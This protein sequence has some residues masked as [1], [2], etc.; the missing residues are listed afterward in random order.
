MHHHSAPLSSLKDPNQWGPPPKRREGGGVASNTTTAP[1]ARSPRSA[2]QQPTAAAAALEEPGEARP[3]KPF[4]ANTTGLDTSHLPKPPVFRGAGRSPSPS[5]QAAAALPKPRPDLPPRLPPRQPSNTTTSMP[6]SPPP[7]Y[8]ATPTPREDGLNQASLNGLG[9]AG[10]DI[11]EL[12]I[13]S[14]NTPSPSTHAGAATPNK[15]TLSE[16]QSRFSTLKTHDGSNSSSTP[17]ST[18]SSTSSAFK[19]AS[20]FR[21]GPSSVS[22]SDLRDAATTAQGIQQQ[23]GSQMAAG[24]QKG[25]EKNDRYGIADKV[26]RVASP[27]SQHSG[28]SLAAAAAGKKVPPPPPPKKKGLGAVHADTGGEAPPPPIPMSSKPRFS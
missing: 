6:S 16:L 15:P 5:R 12:G 26:G 20:S 24:W 3:P 18:L 1:V 4:L 11:P 8:D 25:N 28:S 19:T 7:S 27:D 14:N 13:S 9:R 22:A 10:I 2:P 21:N 23:H 17:K